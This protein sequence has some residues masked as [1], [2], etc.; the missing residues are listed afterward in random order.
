MAWANDQEFCS[1]A[2]IC[3]TV[4]INRRPAHLVRQLLQ[5]KGNLLLHQSWQQRWVLCDIL[6][7]QVYVFLAKDKIVLLKS[8]STSWE[9][10]CCYNRQ[11]SLQISFQKRLT[12]GAECKVYRFLLTYLKSSASTYFI[13]VVV[14]Q[15]K[16][17]IDVL[18]KEEFALA[19]GV[20]LNQ[21]VI[22]CKLS[23]SKF[24]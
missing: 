17:P 18:E 8:R 13:A 24:R 11:K 16:W 7:R 20:A 3:S 1:V 6:S 19:S 12:L 14:F 2:P 21:A 10:F 15:G 9:F 4:V 22:I 5:R 23:L